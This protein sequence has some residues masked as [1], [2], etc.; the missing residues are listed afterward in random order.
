[1]K[2]EATIDLLEEI[3]CCIVDNNLTRNKACGYVKGLAIEINT[4]ELHKEI[5]SD[6]WIDDN[7]IDNLLESEC[8]DD[9]T[10]AIVNMNE[11]IKVLR[12]D[13]IELKSRLTRT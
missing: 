2:I 8:L 12:E 9:Y 10:D 7:D 6:L 3:A 5:K 11:D 4:K 13:I 1:M